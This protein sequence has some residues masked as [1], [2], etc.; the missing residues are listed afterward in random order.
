MANP[1]DFTKEQTTGATIT[2]ENLQS[3]GF[4]LRSRFTVNESLRYTKEKEWLESLRQH[5]G[6]YDPE[7]EARIDKNRSRVYPKITRSKNISVE[8]R[9]HDICYPD[10]GKNWGIEPS[11]D[12]TIPDQSLQRILQEALAEEQ[13]KVI[14]QIK[15]RTPEGQEPTIPPDMPVPQPSDEAIQFKIDQFAKKKC[16]EMEREI[17]DQLLDTKYDEKTKR[18]LRSGLHLGTGLVKGPLVQSKKMQRWVLQGNQYVLDSREVPTPYLE[19]TRL[20]DFYPDMSV[21]EL[22]EAEGIFE[23]HVMTKHD[24]RKLAKRPDFNAEN[25]NEYLRATPEGDASFKWWEIELQQ[26]ATK[27]T[28]G[29]QFFKGRKYEVLEYWGYVDARDL[30]EAGVTVPEEDKD[31]ELEANVW[32]LGQYVIKAVLNPVPKEKRPYYIF[33]FEKD[34]SSIFGRGL[35]RIIRD[36]QETICAAARMTLDNAAICAG[37]Q[38]EINMDLID[39]N[40]DVENIYQFR[41]WK[42]NGIGAD[43]QYPAVRIIKF[44]SHIQEYLMIIKQFMEFGDLETAF[45]TYMLIDPGAAGQ[46]TARGASI[47]QGSI[48]TVV[49]DVA[50]NFDSFNAGIIEGMYDWNIEFSGKEEIKGDY[51]VKA[52]GYTSLIAKELRAQLLSQINTILSEDDRAWLKTREWLEELWKAHDLPLDVLRTEE[53]YRRYVAE[54]SDP[55]VLELQ[56][57]KLAAEIEKMR[58][59]ALGQVA[60]AKKKNIEA[61]EMA[62]G[63]KREAA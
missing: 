7:V 1:T 27:E 26:I 54:T 60:S 48:N 53:E 51:R 23:R 13:A 41:V 17:E 28:E 47:R 3:F 19:F 18:A 45:P 20:W 55:R 31:M 63:G 30:E 24:V 40:E 61:A 52:K 16:R 42:R 33:H 6:I 46:E 58:A 43:A 25:I 4:R 44:D 15:A 56:V 21:T 11:P 32:L 9:L 14:E 8:A 62:A 12:S 34:D 36:T 29:T 38:L 10:T 39:P 49:K 57:Q 2:P 22:D 37:D 59:S 5:N 50:K 35:A